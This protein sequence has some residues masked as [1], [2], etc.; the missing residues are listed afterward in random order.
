MLLL[1]LF[2]SL[3]KQRIIV[4]LLLFGLEEQTRE[5]SLLCVGEVGLLAH[6]VSLTLLSSLQLHVGYFI[7][8]KMAAGQLR[9]C[10]SDGRRRWLGAG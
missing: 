9:K 2:L 3:V 6:V 5:A 8:A 7:V 1:L 4:Q 10:M